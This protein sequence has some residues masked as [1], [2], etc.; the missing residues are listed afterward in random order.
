MAKIQTDG[1]Y[2]LIIG[3]THSP[4]RDIESLMKLLVCLDEEDIQLVS[5]QYNSYFTR[6]EISPGIYSIKNVS[7]VLSLGFEN[8][9]EIRGRIRLNVKYDKSDLIIID[10]DNVTMR[11]NMIVKGDIIALRFDRKSFFNSILGLLPDWDYK[12]KDDYF[13]ESFLNLHEIEKIHLKCD[14]ID[15]PL[16]HVVS[17]LVCLVSF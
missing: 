3:Y 16:V 14:V 10:C 17:Q 7:D 11:T 15:G 9:L 1:F 12:R 6:Y 13:G 2:I 4:F 8:E 5:K